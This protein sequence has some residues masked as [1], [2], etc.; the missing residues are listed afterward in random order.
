MHLY[1]DSGDVDEGSRMQVW[2][3]PN[4]I[5]HQIQKNRTT[6]AFEMPSMWWK[7]IESDRN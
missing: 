3:L 2:R 6:M 7:N 5:L 1:L 4:G